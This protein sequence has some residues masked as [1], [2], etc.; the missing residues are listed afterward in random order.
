MEGLQIATLFFGLALA[1]LRASAPRIQRG[2]E[3]T[4]GSRATVADQRASGSGATRLQSQFND[5]RNTIPSGSGAAIGFQQ[6]RD[7]VV[8]NVHTES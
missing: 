6:H 5:C 8:D 7:C 2:Q 1:T 3:G 4:I